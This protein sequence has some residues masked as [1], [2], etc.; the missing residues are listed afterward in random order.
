MAKKKID[1]SIMARSRLWLLLLFVGLNMIGLTSL[2]VNAANLIIEDFESPVEADNT[3]TPG[4]AGWTWVSNVKS[5]INGTVPGSPNQALY[6]EWTSYEAYYDIDHAWAAGNTYVLT[7]KAS[8]S[9]WNGS[10]DRYIAPSLRQQD[11]TVLW[12][13]N[14][15]MPKY[16]SYNGNPWTAAQTFTWVIQSDDFSTGTAG[17]NLR[18]RLDHTGQRGIYIDDV[19]LVE[20]ALPVDNT[21]PSPDPMGW[22]TAPTVVDFVNVTMT[23]NLAIDDPYGVQYLFENVTTGANSGWQSNLL[24]NIWTQANLVAGNTYTYRVKARDLSPNL[25]ETAWSNSG[26][27]VTMDPPDV[28][29]PTPN[30]MTWSVSPRVVDEINIYM[31][32]STATDPYLGVEYYI[33]NMTTGANSGWQSSS[34][35][36]EVGKAL[37]TQHTYRVKSRDLSPNQNTTAWSNSGG[38]VTIANPP[39]GRRLLVSGNFEY[40]VYSNGTADPF[41]VGWSMT[42]GSS[43]K[44]RTNA[45]TSD[46]PESP[47]VV[48]QLEQLNAEPNYDISHNWASSDV[49]TLTINASPMSWSGTSTRHIAPSLLQQ[50]NTVLWSS[51]DLL[52]IYDNQGG[53]PWAA[54]LIFTYT[55]PASAFGAGTVGQPLRLKIDQVANRGIYIDNIR[56][57]LAPVATGTI[58]RID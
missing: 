33:E 9:S 5:R 56:L 39:E 42:N 30:P 25:N 55:I 1:N 12:S 37:D 53:N 50:D 35:W 29:A 51:A 49:Y 36:Y 17:S 26:G 47:N 16:D 27:N 48:I 22:I 21:P 54:N 3:T 19:E 31:D 10:L 32:A 7:L 8:P 57:I 2:Q 52:P 13:A 28:T 24:S 43:I 14:E 4:F 45:A 38:N 46:V 34:V 6:F 18:L 41:F 40:P 58:F 15:M 11:G 20:G 23:S 44:L